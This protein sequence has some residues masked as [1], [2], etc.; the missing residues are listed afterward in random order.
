MNMLLCIGDSLTFG[1]IGYSYIKYLSPK[2]QII[3]KGVNGDTVCCLYKRLLSCV[4]NQRYAAADT[5]V[6][7]IGTNDVLLPYLGKNS[8][9]FKKQLD[10]RA[11]MKKCVLDDAEFAMQYEKCIKLLRDS[12]KQAILV[13]LPF[14]QLKNYVL[15]D[16]ERKN[17]IIFELAQKYKMKYV[18]I[19]SL[20]KEEASQTA[21]DAYEFSF[22]KSA[23]DMTVMAVLPFTK[24]LFSKRRKLEL[25]VDGIH[26]NA[27]SAKLLADALT[28]C[29]KIMSDEPLQ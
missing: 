14:I 26:Y 28:A 24:E 16:V 10:M 25:T 20:Q 8:K 23:F 12:G 3:N 1:S 27:K 29:L 19:F 4:G 18:D 21:F 7:A 6:L 17:K 11:R 13:G 5:Y 22:F 2:L 9:L 15:D